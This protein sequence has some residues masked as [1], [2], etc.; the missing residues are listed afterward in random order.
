MMALIDNAKR[1]RQNCTLL[2]ADAHK[3]FDKLWLEDCL[4]DLRKAGMRE[5]EVAMI[6]KLNEKAIMEVDTLMEEQN[7]WH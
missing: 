3:C 4:V 1:S 5:R 2:F 6:L 7:Q